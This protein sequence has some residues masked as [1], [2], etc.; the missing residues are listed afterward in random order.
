METD[1][2]PE[3][4]MREKEKQ[5]VKDLIKAQGGGVDKGANQTGMYE[6]CG[7]CRL[8]RSRCRDGHG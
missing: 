3:E 4:T 8:P 5:E 7:E 6:L 2:V 1:E